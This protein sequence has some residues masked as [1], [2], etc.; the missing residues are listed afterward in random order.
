[1]VKLL[2]ATSLSVFKARRLNRWVLTVV[3]RRNDRAVI[4]REFI[5]IRFLKHLHH[6]H[7]ITAGC[8]RQEV[9]FLLDSR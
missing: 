2:V 8:L 9:R 6:I 7:L 4:R 1:L 5:H 3:L